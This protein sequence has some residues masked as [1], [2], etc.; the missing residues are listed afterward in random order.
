MPGIK[1]VSWQTCIV[2]AA[3]KLSA[4]FGSSAPATDST[5]AADGCI[6]VKY[7]LSAVS[8]PT[9]TKIHV[10]PKFVDA[11]GTETWAALADGSLDYV[12]VITANYE[13]PIFWDVDAIAVGAEVW[14]DATDAAATCTLMIKRIYPKV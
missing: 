12:S 11:D 13:T 6:G 2:A 9:A 10:C 4:T 8:L 3:T 1:D 14:L 5:F 7:K